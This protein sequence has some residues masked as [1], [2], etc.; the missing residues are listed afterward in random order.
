MKERERDGTNEGR[1]TLI[2]V[3]SSHVNL[4]WIYYAGLWDKCYCLLLEVVPSCNKLVANNFRT[5]IWSSDMIITMII[6]KEEG[7]TIFYI[8]NQLKMNGPKKLSNPWK[9]GALTLKHR[10]KTLSHKPFTRRW[11]WG[12]GGHFVQIE[13]FQVTFVTY[14]ETITSWHNLVWW[15]RFYKHLSPTK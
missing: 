10:S 7:N 9:R 6:H 4:K 8:I 5:I 15:T 12:R 11:L 3:T 2:I 13:I 14:L 1:F